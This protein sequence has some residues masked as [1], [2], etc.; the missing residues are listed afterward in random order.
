MASCLPARIFPEQCGGNLDG[1]F[2]RLRVATFNTLALNGKTH[3]AAA[4]GRFLMQWIDN[5]DIILLQ[6]VHGDRTSM[7]LL[8]IHF[9]LMHAFLLPFLLT[10]T[11]IQ[12][13]LS[14]W[15][16]E[17]FACIPRR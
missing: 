13:D 3:R 16:H 17:L 2:Q 8:M 7:Q 1:D 12:E 14:S 5:Y 6:E 11:I 15:L 9:Q 10:M 4:K